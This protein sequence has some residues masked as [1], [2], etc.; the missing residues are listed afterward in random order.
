MREPIEATGFTVRVIYL[1][2]AHVILTAGLG[3]RVE[4][5]PAPVPVRTTGL[6][7]D[8]VGHVP[9]AGI[10]GPHVA[11]AALL[12][13]NLIARSRNALIR[14]ALAR[15]ALGAFRLTTNIGAEAG[16]NRGGR[17]GY[18]CADN[19]QGQFKCDASWLADFR[20][21]HDSLPCA[22]LSRDPRWSRPHERRN[23]A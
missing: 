17:Q 10:A 13:V 2:G 1:S 7:G 6:V 21:S 20:A 3:I 9:T 8:V 12:Y 16:D 5:R 22:K 18:A 23:G 14:T 15:L 19:Q 4:D 11:V